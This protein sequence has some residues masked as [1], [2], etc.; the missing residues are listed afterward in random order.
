[1][2][3]EEII[4]GNKLIAEFLGF[5]V[6]STSDTSSYGNGY[7]TYLYSKDGITLY[8]VFYDCSWDWLMPVVEKIEDLDFIVSILNNSCCV[9]IKGKTT[10]ESVTKGYIHSEK[11]KIEATWKAVVKFIEWYD[12]QKL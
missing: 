5:K 10:A 6:R 4:D 11:S 12:A 2:T 8:S 1:M 9:L 3:A 7:T